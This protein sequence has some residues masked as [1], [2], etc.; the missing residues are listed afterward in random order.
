MSLISKRRWLLPV[1]VGALSVITLV[2]VACGDDDDDSGSNSSASGADVTILQSI[3]ILDGAGLHGIDDGINK[4][5]AIPATARTVALQM[6]TTLA[7]TD[8]PSD[9]DAK[10]TALNKV[11]QEFATV[12]DAD[13]PDIA[14]AGD[15]AHQAHE[16]AH[17]FS[18][19]VWQYLYKKAGVEVADAGGHD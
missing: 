7:L 13:S 3:K 14:K 4:D 8:W 6:R 12:L 9:L 15:L 2:S 17:E 10:A 1:L 19:D 18:H 5:K 16:G 11:F